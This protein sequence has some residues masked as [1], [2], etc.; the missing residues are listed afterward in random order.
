MQRGVMASWNASHV[1]AARRARRFPSRSVRELAHPAHPAFPG[2][3]PTGLSRAGAA[4]SPRGGARIR[5]PR[6]RAPPAAP[7]RGPDPRRRHRRLERFHDRVSFQPDHHP[8]LPTRQR[9]R[10]AAVRHLAASRHHTRADARVSPRSREE[11]L[12][13]VAARVRTR[14]GTVSERVP[15]QLGDRGTRGVLRVEVHERRARPG[16]LPHAAARC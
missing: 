9:S 2:P 13:R 5:V 4:R 10:V 8:G 6:R 12:G 16:Q 11:L 15:A 3:L 14:P 1:T 7:G